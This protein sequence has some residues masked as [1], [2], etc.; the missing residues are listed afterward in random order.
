MKKKTPKIKSEPQ[1]KKEP[2]ISP[3]FASDDRGSIFWSFSL[4]DCDGPWGFDSICKN[5]LHNLITSGFKDKEGISWA[6]LKA[7]GYKIKKRKHLKKYIPQDQ[8]NL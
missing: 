4:I 3:Q 2:V 7:N 8:P 1:R 5:E 6:E